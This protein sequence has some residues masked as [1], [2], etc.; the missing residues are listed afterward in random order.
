MFRRPSDPPEP[1]LPLGTSDTITTLHAEWGRVH[2]ASTSAVTMRQRMAR[3]V[4]AQTARMGLGTD[5][6]MLGDLIRAID[7][8]ATR[9]DELSDRVSSLEVLVDDMARI[10]GEEV[11][12]LRAAVEQSVTETPRGSSSSAQ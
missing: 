10:L 8:V 6:K 12:R 11:T 4:R 2:A 1:P 5:R 9:C 3:K 7:A